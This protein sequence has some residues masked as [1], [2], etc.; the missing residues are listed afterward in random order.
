VIGINTNFASLSAQKSLSTTQS[1]LQTAIERLSSG[2]RVNSAK[3]DAAGLAIAE[4]MTAQIR[5]SEVAARNANDGISL[6]QIADGAMSSL[7]QNLQRMRELAVQAKNGTLGSSDRANLNTEFEELAGEVGRVATGTEFNGL[8]LFATANKTF[9]MQVG[10][11]NGTGDTLSINLTEDGTSSGDDLQTALGG[12]TAADIKT[13]F[14]DITSVA[15]ATTAI[16]TIDSKLDTITTLRSVAGAGLS[17]LDQTISNLQN[18]SANISMAR[19]R[20]LDADF[21]RETAQLTRSQILQ[22]AGSAMLVQANQLPNTVLT[23][24]KG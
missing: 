9:S 24:L 4:R 1:G 19:G 10:A 20:I 18:S 14:G 16:T 7:T 12:T 3:D 21:A 13:A 23:L 8:D 6:L 11:G 2:L 15:G 22:Q 5:G 17:R